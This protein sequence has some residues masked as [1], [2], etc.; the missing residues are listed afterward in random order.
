MSLTKGLMDSGLT[1][2]SPAAGKGHESQSLIV[3]AFVEWFGA[4]SREERD[5]GREV[6]QRQAI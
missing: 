5:K 6:A 2:T 1:F 3:F 4:F